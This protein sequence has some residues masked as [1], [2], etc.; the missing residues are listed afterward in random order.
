MD[1]LVTILAVVI[2]L[3]MLGMVIVNSFFQRP[4]AKQ[5]A[6]ELLRSVLTP[7]QYKQL[8]GH[9][10][11]DIPSP[12]NPERIYRVP[13]SAGRVQVRERGKL[14]MYLCLQPYEPVPDADVV[15]IHKL[16]IEAD[17]E[18]YLQKANRFIPFLL[19]Y[20]E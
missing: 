12:S 4:A 6:G 17:E 9:G 10:Y 2:V 11:I 16:M 5:R 19:N 3:V 1:L 13:H 7:E 20:S 15:V 8:I 14:T 18:A